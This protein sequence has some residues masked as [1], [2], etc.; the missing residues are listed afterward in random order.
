MAE[1]MRY[2]GAGESGAEAALAILKD[3][4][5]T[6]NMVLHQLSGYGP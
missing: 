6:A 4:V 5:E 1:E 3:A 2:L